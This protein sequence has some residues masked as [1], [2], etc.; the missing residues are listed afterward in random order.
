MPWGTLDSSHL[1]SW[2]LIRGHSLEVPVVCDLPLS[3]ITCKS[4]DLKSFVSGVIIPWT[5]VTSGACMDPRAREG[6]SMIGNSQQEIP[7]AHALKAQNISKARGKQQPG[8]TGQSCTELQHQGPERRKSQL[9]VNRMRTSVPAVK[10]PRTCTRVPRAHLSA[11]ECA[12]RLEEQRG[13]RS[14]ISLWR[15]EAPPWSRI[16]A[17]A[18]RLG[19]E[20]KGR[21]LALLCQR[22]CSLPW[23]WKIAE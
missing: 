15:D 13:L 18:P 22:S 4:N 16:R 9:K 8:L 5:S 1:V 7:G 17:W 20:H 6:V 14:T 19:E 3:W 10:G 21:T 2:R 12:W 23:A 11:P